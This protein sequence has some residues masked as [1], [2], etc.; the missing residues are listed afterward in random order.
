MLDVMTFPSHN[1]PCESC[2]SC[3]NCSNY[4]SF[5]QTTPCP[6]HQRKTNRK[7]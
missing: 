7:N 2:L 3:S 5:L 6:F 1:V 4:L